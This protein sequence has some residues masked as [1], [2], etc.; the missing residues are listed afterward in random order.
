[1]SRPRRL[2]GGQRR[3]LLQALGPLPSLAVRVSAVNEQEAIHYARELRDALAEARWPVTGV[4]KCHR[5]AGAT[6]V[7]LAVRNVVAPP[8]EAIALMN[9][10]RRIGIPANWHH[11]PGLS[12]DRI[13]EVRIG[14]ASVGA[15]DESR[16]DEA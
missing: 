2:G 4:F 16:L 10:L 11:E 7:T 8:G 15:A 9:T 5:D 13:I 12:G 14:G 1:M 6:G 3:A